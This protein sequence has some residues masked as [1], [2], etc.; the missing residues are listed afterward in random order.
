MQTGGKNATISAVV[1]NMY[2]H[3]PHVNMIQSQVIYTYAPS[4]YPNTVMI[5]VRT[6]MPS[7][8]INTV[9]LKINTYAQWLSG[10]RYNRDGYATPVAVLMQSLEI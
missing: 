9:T 7:G 2:T 4:S 3:M 10:Y 5:N 8:N 6:H 1:I